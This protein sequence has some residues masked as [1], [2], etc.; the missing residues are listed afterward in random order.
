[1][2]LVLLKWRITRSNV[3]L[4]TTLVLLDEQAKRVRASYK[5]HWEVM[6]NIAPAKFTWT[7][8][9]GTGDVVDN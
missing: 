9:E 2:K 3:Q 7:S 4:V 5:R 8:P 6:Q 1:M